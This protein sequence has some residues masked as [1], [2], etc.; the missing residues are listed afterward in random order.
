MRTTRERFCFAL[1][2]L[3]PVID[4][5]AALLLRLSRTSYGPGNC[6]RVTQDSSTAERKCGITT[7][8]A[9]KNGSGAKDSGYYYAG[10]REPVEFGFV[11]E[12]S[13]NGAGVARST[14]H[15]FGVN[16]FAE[17]EQWVSDV[18]CPDGRCV[19][20]TEALLSQI[21]PKRTGQLG[22]TEGHLREGGN[23]TRSKDTESSSTSMRI[24][25]LEEKVTQLQKQVEVSR[26]ELVR[27]KSEDSTFNTAPSDGNE[28]SLAEIVQQQS[29]DYSPFDAEVF[30]DKRGSTAGSE[31]G[32]P[33]QN[34]APSELVVQNSGGVESD[35]SAM[36]IA[37]LQQSVA[38]VG[39]EMQRESR[40]AD[41]GGAPESEEDTGSDEQNSDSVDPGQQVALLQEGAVAEY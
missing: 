39:A 16:T 35:F 28:P 9:T 29:N 2:C 38:Q 12:R 19:A 6:V 31:E 13:G 30:G 33:G 22:P 3:F 41:A 40:L 10:S 14:Y 21:R 32:A 27:R 37:K 11:C 24:Q 1:L 34:D 15:S 23:N 8:C 36:A 18:S 20:P 5:A 17:N 26:K 4:T 25:D 7:S